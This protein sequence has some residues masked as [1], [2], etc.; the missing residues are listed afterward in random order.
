MVS[1]LEAAS[2]EAAHITHLLFPSEASISW[3]LHINILRCSINKC[4]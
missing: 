1:T 3:K 2:K 4:Q